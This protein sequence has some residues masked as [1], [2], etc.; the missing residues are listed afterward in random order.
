MILVNYF[1]RLKKYGL[2]GLVRFATPV[3]STIGFVAILTACSVSGPQGPQPVFNATDDTKHIFTVD[4]LEGD[5]QEALEAEYNAKVLIWK[6]GAGFAILGSNLDSSFFPQSLEMDPNQD[7]IG[8]PVSA[9][10]DN[11]GWASGINDWDDDDWEEGDDDNWSSGRDG[12]AVGHNGWVTGENGWQAGVNSAYLEKNEDFWN[13]IDLFGA[14]YSSK[15]LGYGVKIAVIDTGIDLSHS[16]FAQSLAPQN[17]WRDFVDKDL[18]PQD[19]MGG[20]GS[21]HGTAVTGIILQV[22]PQATIL[23]IRVLDT[24]GFGNMDHI[25]QAIDH[26]VASGADIINL[27]LGSDVKSETMKAM[28][29]YAKSQDVFTVAAAGNTAM[30]DK[31]LYPSKMSGWGDYKG[32]LFA[33][34]SVDKDDAISEFSTSRSHNVVFAPGE[35]IRSAF[36]GEK[37]VNVS[38]TS[39]ATPIFAGSLALA[40]SELDTSTKRADIFSYV[41]SGLE[42]ERIDQNHYASGGSWKHGIGVLDANA[43]VNIALIDN[44]SFEQN[45]SLYSWDSYRTTIAKTFNNG[46]YGKSGKNL[47]QLKPDGYLRQSLSKLR[48]NTTY[49][50]KM[51]IGFD[52]SAGNAVIGL[53]N[54]RNQDYQVFKNISGYQKPTALVYVSTT[55]TTGNTNNDMHFFIENT[56]ASDIYVDEF[57]LKAIRTED[58]D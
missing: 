46:T 22:A 40:F 38:G 24:D 56:E 47:A 2:T 9:L 54:D 30:H 11:N 55:F 8:L 20:V 25:I 15:T 52:D 26:A 39:F 19:E 29:R 42:R 27:S 7:S 41:T 34:G 4:L 14:H 5:T 32:S 12:W 6:E 10:G 43:L 3:I 45:N 17:E 16:M 58:D 21:G 23:P 33:V 49:E 13:Q 57:R 28:L 50:L 51:R 18:V 37:R 1:E 44:P 48:P 31:L 53:Y 36:P 35:K